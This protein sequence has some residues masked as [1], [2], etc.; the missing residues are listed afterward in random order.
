LLAELNNIIINKDDEINDLKDLVYHRS[1]DAEKLIKALQ[2]A[3]VKLIECMTQIRDMAD[4]KE[5][6]NK[7]L[8]ELKA[9]VQVVVDLVDPPEKGLISKRMLLEQL[10]EAPQKISGYI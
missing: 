5:L 9:A 6:K 2:D 10:H 3:D 7:E 4:E 1:D 8:E